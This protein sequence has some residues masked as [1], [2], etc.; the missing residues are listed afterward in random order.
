[1]LFLKR[2]I[3]PNSS[4]IFLFLGT[5]NPFNHDYWLGLGMSLQRCQEY[6]RAIDAYELASLANIESPVPYFYLG[7]CLFAIHDRE[8]ALQALEL[9][10]EMAEEQEEYAELK[11]QAEAAKQ[12]I[13]KFI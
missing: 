4:D 11:S 5:L 10:I 6:E 2:A 8:N 9:A 1:M 7:K 12:A 3:F 13:S